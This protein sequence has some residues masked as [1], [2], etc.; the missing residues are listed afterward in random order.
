MPDFW[1]GCG[2]R[3]LS[4]SDDRRL[5]VTDDFLRT[6][7]LRP[8]LSPIPQSSDAELRLHDRLLAD[9]R[10]DV[11]AAEIDAIDDA[12]VRDN[13]RIW[14][15]FRE[16]L[17]AADT[18]EAVYAQL[19]QGEGVDVAPVFVHRLT[20][21]IC[22]HIL[23]DDADPLEARMAEMLFRLQ[24]I[25]V[26]EDGAVMAADGETVD[27]YATDGGFGSLGELL[28]QQKTQLRS[29]D[30]DVID[31]ENADIYWTRDERFDTAVS[32]NRGRP[33]LDALC[34]IL[35]RWVLHFH[36]AAVT[37]KPQREIDD[38][39]WVWHVGLD[40]EASSLLND[41]YNEVDVDEMRLG[42]LLCLFQ[43]D[44]VDPNDMREQLRGRPVYLAMAMDASNR[45]RLKPQNLLLNL[46]LARVS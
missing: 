21:V 15:R 37:I 40:A 39:R 46:P 3:H 44:F 41:L 14:L 6:D 31:R 11:T 38:K 26:L 28:R 1:P 9:P 36:G 12:D 30:L 24:R 45:L 27:R 10:R 18:L 32:L 2:Y 29:V 22:R 35:E 17:L 7:L 23:G 13:L 43:L 5:I 42:R 8:E 34:R 25:S 4:I 20:Q 33:G 16:R 19:F